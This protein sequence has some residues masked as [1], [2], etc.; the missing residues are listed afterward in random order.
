MTVGAVALAAA[1]ARTDG[2]NA[3]LLARWTAA[4]RA[5]VPADRR[6]REPG[7]MP[8]D[9]GVSLQ[10]VAARELAVPGRYR[11][12][13]P[14]AP[15]PEPTWWQRLWSW[16]HDR[17]DD[18]WSFVFGRVALGSRAA[19]AIGDAAL[20]A[21]LLALWRLAA[22]FGG[23]RRAPSNARPLPAPPDAAALYAR[24]CARAGEGRYADAARLLFAATLAV[25]DV[26][27]TVRENAS[28]TVG[29]VRR[30]LR[31]R[32]APAVPAFDDV[33]SA[34]VAGTYAQRPVAS[35]DWERARSAYAR[36]AEETPA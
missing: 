2:E 4:A 8:P 10:R 14:A 32:A 1:L 13:S 19:A 30:E 5:A 26:K 17:W 20:I 29:D 36:L 34:F 15:R 7:S 6:L 25:L 11:L 3:A 31:A 35:G 22:A 18:F 12:A 27:G 33:A 21:V 16:L 23:R 9:P 24:A 28:A